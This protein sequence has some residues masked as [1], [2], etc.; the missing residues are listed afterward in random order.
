MA[1]DVHDLREWTVF[2]RRLHLPYYEEV[3]QC[4]QGLR[5][6]RDG[7]ANEIYLYLPDTLKQIIE[8]RESDA[9]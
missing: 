9:A 1:P 5:E 7:G 2:F 8:E 3:R 4:T 6:E